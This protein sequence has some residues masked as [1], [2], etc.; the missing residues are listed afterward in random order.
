MVMAAA[1]VVSLMGILL[2]YLIYSRKTISR[3]WFSSR[4][5]IT[6]GI[7]SRKFFI[8]EFY[9]L[10]IVYAVKAVSLFLRFI[11]LF[12]VEGLVKLAAGTVN[13]LGKAG[14]RMQNGQVQ[15]YGMAAFLGLA[16]LVVIFALTG[17]YL[18]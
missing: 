4:A 14:A 1:I 15:T 12:L 3:D 6:Y 11:E 9:Q 5:P 8:D 10:S 7:V 18:R 13:T 16:L 17:G 2:A